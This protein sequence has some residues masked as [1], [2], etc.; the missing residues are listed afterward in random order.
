MAS[1]LLK[2]QGRISLSSDNFDGSGCSGTDKT[3]NRTLNVPNG[4]GFVIVERKVIHPTDDYTVSGT[5]ITFLI[6]ID[7]RMKISVFR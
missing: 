5:T 3:T 6:R 7:N 1:I 4:I 2:S